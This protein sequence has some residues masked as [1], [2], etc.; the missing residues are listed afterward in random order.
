[1]RSGFSV[2]VLVSSFLL[3]ASCEAKFDWP[4]LKDTDKA[5]VLG[6]GDAEDRSVD[7]FVRIDFEGI[8]K[9]VFDSTVPTGVLKITATPELRA[10]IE[11]SV[12]N[13]TLRISEKGIQGPGSWD[14][15]FRLAPP[16][17]LQ[18]VVLGGMGTIESTAPL[19]T[20]QP[21]AVTIRGMGKI[22]LD[23]AA[24]QVAARQTGS[25]ELVLR[26]TAGSVSVLAQGLG[27]VDVKD[28]QTKT[29]ELSSQ[30]VGEVEVFASEKLKVRASGLG[31]VRFYGHPATTD[32]QTEG[33]TKVTAGD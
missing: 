8:G 3:L 29:A 27:K 20:D 23:V 13:G 30:G 1:M 17:G 2:V 19:K 22:E 5:A 16:A 33:L 4:W 24:P 18:E 6:T 10:K 32:V 9:L 7:A 14:L 15:E 31:A 26:G 11:T 28:L 25:G 21:L 12:S